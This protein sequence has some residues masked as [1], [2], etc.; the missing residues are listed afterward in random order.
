[1]APH[2]AYNRGN[3]RKRYT[4][5][6]NNRHANGADACD[7]PWYAKS[8]LDA[9][10]TEVLGQADYEDKFAAE[11]KELRIYKNHLE[12]EFSDGRKIKWQK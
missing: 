10:C 9:A 12:F 2:T 4:F 7:N 3:R 6:C 5:V 11:I 8:K 1:M